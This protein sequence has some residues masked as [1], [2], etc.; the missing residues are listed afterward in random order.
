[1]NETPHISQP[2]PKQNGIYAG[3]ARGFDGEPDGHIIL[4]DDKPEERMNWKD[5][6]AW[7]ASLG[8]GAKLPTRFEA[9]LIGA[10]IADKISPSNYWSSS[11]YSATNSWYQYW[12]SSYPGAQFNDGK[13]NAYYVRA[14]RRLIL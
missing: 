4:L 13:T 10:N 5:A 6:M 7:A 12:S 14:V 9:L 11:E 8:N 2:W 1:M 3:I